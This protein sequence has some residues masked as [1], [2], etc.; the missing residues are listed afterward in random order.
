M[1]DDNTTHRRAF[2][3]VTGVTGVAA[4]AG[5]TGGGGGGG[6]EETTSGGEETTSADEST[7]TP[8]DTPTATESSG[9]SGPISMGSIMPITGA[10]SAYGSGMQQAANLAVQNINDAGGILGGRE[11]QIT[12]KDSGTKPSNAIQ[13]YNSLVNENDIVGF[14]GAASSGV[15]VPIAQKVHDDKVMQVSHASTTPALAE[16]G[17][18]SD[19]EPPK[20]FARTAPNDGQQGIVMARIMQNSEFIDADTAAFLHV[21]NP[22]GKGLAQRAKEAFEG[23]T[24][25]LVPYGKKTTDYSSTLDKL[26][27]GDPDAIGF[28]GYPGNG[29][30]ILQQ[31]SQGGYGTESSDWVL[32][33]GLNSNEFLQNNSSIT[34]SMYLASPDPEATEGASV[35]EDR[36]GEANTLFA[37]H[38]YD[39]IVL[40]A[41]AMQQAGEASG[42]A[43]AE[44]IQSVSAGDGTT[45]T[46]GELETAISELEAGNAINYQGASSPVNLNDSL[47]PLNRFAILQ[48]QD[49]GTKTSLKQIP[50]SEF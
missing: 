31:W 40:Q 16:I 18:G 38:A 4:L 28:V 19:G 22:Y 47:E 41:L 45:V 39:A 23:E 50:R 5:C 14:V 35:F 3:K 9:G 15:S 6:G 1:P 11:I 37:A 32:S 25:Q 34:A 42:T 10:L 36:I 21:A 8:T 24:L 7:P 46:V 30:T 43:I 29:K 2:L 48:I 49:D 12:N 27:A 44:N 20:Y 13:K 26:H 17:Y 33:E